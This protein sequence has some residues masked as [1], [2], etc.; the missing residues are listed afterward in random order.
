MGGTISA[1]NRIDRSGAVFT[2]ELPIP[3]STVRIGPTP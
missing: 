3:T 2:L 1:G